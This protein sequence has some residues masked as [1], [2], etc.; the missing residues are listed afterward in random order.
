M[1]SLYYYIGANPTVDLVIFNPEGKILVIKRGPDYP[2]C[3]DM[4]ALPG[5]FIDSHAQKGEVWRQDLETPETAALRE[6]AEEANLML[7][8]VTI[9]PV[10]IYEGNQRDPRDNDVSWSKSHAFYYVIDA[11][12]YEAQKDTIKAAAG[13]VADTDWKSPEELRATLMAFDHN[14]IIED[15]LVLYYAAQNNVSV[16]KKKF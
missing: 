9:I 16:P 11:Q 8:N 12:T 3:A 1:K 13:E 6:T 15:A 10:G 5:G 2:V 7:K 4:W 14:K